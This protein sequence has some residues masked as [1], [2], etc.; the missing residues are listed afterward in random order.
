[1]ARPVLRQPAA[2]AHAAHVLGPAAPAA[3]RRA[4]HG[5]EAWA[6][7]QRRTP[8]PGALA[9]QARANASLQ[10]PARATAQPAFKAITAS[11][12]V[13]SVMMSRASAQ[14]LEQGACRGDD[15]VARG[16]GWHRL[17]HRPPRRAQRHQR[18]LLAAGGQAVRTQPRA[19]R[20]PPPPVA[21]ARSRQRRRRR[22]RLEHEAAHDIQ[23]ALPPR[24]VHLPPGQRDAAHT[25][26]A[27]AAD[28]SA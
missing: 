24:A 13:K 14:P 22:E 12:T 2:D 23:T 16:G 7:P 5:D 10:L 15:G 4:A 26:A 17:R 3:A 9:P 27:A 19:A 28:A 21:P 8:P 25:A 18:R 20:L 1:M 11:G 6:R